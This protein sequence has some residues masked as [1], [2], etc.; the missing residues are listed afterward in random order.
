MLIEARD[1]KQRCST[2]IFPE[3]KVHC[4]TQGWSME[5]IE[6]FPTTDKMKQRSRKSQ[7]I[8][9]VREMDRKLKLENK[10]VSPKGYHEQVP[11]ALQN[12]S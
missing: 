5:G 2:R 6:I 8:Y 3:V 4:N 9:Q 12:N 11:T 1:R 10:T 7:K